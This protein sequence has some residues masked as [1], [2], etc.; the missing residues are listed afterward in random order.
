MNLQ[1]PRL[2]AFAHAATLL[3]CGVSLPAR[4]QVYMGS[5]GHG[6]AIV[7]SNFA[8]PAAPE[9][10]IAGP[11]EP[12]SA[13]SLPAPVAAPIPAVAARRLP[14]STPALRRVIDDVARQVGVAAPL[15]HA[16]IAAESAYDPRARSPRGAMGLMQLMPATASR[17][18]VHDPF[19][20]RE[21]ILAGATYLKFLMGLFAGDLPLVLAAYNA[22]EQAVL[23]AGRRIPA[24]TET[25]AYVPRVLSYLRCADDPQCGPI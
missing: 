10:L 9:L 4:A 25:Q 11:S 12:G 22:G 13:K 21:N 7:L 1:P 15:L 24:F 6:S 14:R 23:N 17:F 8:S 20:P 16:V 3:A 18:G 5:E 2:I 19:E